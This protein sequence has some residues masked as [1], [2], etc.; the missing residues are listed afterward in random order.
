[1]QQTPRLSLSQQRNKK[2]LFADFKV[3]CNVIGIRAMRF[4][5]FFT[6]SFRGICAFLPVSPA[7]ACGRS[8]VQSLHPRKKGLQKCSGF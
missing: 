8:F 7:A 4:S 5:D 3:I 6:H 1:M 2:E